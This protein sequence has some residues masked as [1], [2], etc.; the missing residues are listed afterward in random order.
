MTGS[1][2]ICI[3]HVFLWKNILNQIENVGMSNNERNTIFFA[4]SSRFYSRQ[5][6][7][8]GFIQFL[9]NSAKA[10]ND[11]ISCFLNWLM[12]RWMR[13]WLNWVSLSHSKNHLEKLIN[14]HSNT[15][16][17]PKQVNYGKYYLGVKI[18]HKSGT[19][20]ITLV[21]SVLENSLIY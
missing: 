20:Q 1:T 16:L 12:V 19:R 11:E 21:T 4:V 7:F 2:T 15:V 8:R 14:L 17:K 10:K 18:K 3:S 5:N 13:P 6:V 9:S